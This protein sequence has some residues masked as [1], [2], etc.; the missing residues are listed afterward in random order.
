MAVGEGDQFAVHPLVQVRTVET[1]GL[2]GEFDELRHLGR[3][4]LKVLGYVFNLRAGGNGN[5]QQ[6]CQDKGNKG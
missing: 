4:E 3:L 1:V 5:C 2:S 6:G